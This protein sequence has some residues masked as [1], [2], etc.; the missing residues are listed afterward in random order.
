MI[1]I[2]KTHVPKYQWGTRLSPPALTS[3]QLFPIFAG[4]HDQWWW[5]F[6]FTKMWLPFMISQNGKLLMN[7]KLF[8]HIIWKPKMCTTQCHQEY[9]FHCGIMFFLSLLILSCPKC[10]ICIFQTYIQSYIGIIFIYIAYLFTCNKFYLHDSTLSRLNIIFLSTL[11][12]FVN[13]FNVMLWFC[14]CV[15]QSVRTYSTGLV[16]LKAVWGCEAFALSN[17]TSSG[18]KADKS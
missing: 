13:I 11:L 4:L 2:I 1:R 7:F 18:Y 10:L 6:S 5:I 17:M 8:Q 14:S 9:Y 3:I 12:C 15:S 16:V